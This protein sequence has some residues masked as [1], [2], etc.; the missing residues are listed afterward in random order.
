MKDKF[1]GYF[2]LPDEQKKE[3]F[4]T[5]TFV[6]DACVLLNVYSYSDETREEFLD[7]LEK[8]KDRIWVPHQCAMEF[9]KNRPS[10]IKKQLEKFDSQL[11]L[12]EDFATNFDAAHRERRAH[13]FYS[14]KARTDT[15]ALVE[16]LSNE[17]TKNKVKVKQLLHVDPCL[18][19]TSPSPRD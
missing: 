2:P 9:L 11:K 3:L 16:L 8:L 19:Y 12:V 5:A 4:K 17:L 14:Q 6:L 1:P 15:E 10:R 7:L 13:P 18:L